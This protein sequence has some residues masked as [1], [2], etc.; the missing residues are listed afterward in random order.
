LATLGT[1]HFF[2]W[3]GLTHTHLNDSSVEKNLHITQFKI[4]FID[5]DLHGTY[6]QPSFARNRSV[7]IGADSG[8]RSYNY[9]SAQFVAIQW[10]TRSSAVKF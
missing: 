6:P 1:I 8:L 2:W 7:G 9:A 10:G 4:S 5:L 3:L